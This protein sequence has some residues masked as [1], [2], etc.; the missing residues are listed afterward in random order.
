M[1]LKT[2]IA[3][4]NLSSG[5]SSDSVSS[6]E[7]SRQN[8]H[9][10]SVSGSRASSRQGS[11]EEEPSFVPNIRL[12]T[13]ITF[14]T[15]PSSMTFTDNTVTRSTM[16]KRQKPKKVDLGHRRASD[17]NFQPNIVVPN[18]RPNISVDP[19]PS[20]QGDQLASSNITS[21]QID[22][23]SVNIK[24]NTWSSPS[25]VVP[26]NLSRAASV[27]PSMPGNVVSRH[28]VKIP[29]PATPSTSWFSS[30]MVQTAPR[31]EQT[32]SSSTHSQSSRSEHTI[33]DPPAAKLSPPT[34]QRLKS[35]IQYPDTQQKSNIVTVTVPNTVGHG[36]LGQ[37][38]ASLDLPGS[39]HTEAGAIGAS[40]I[41]EEESNIP[42][43]KMNFPVP[44]TS[45]FI[46]QQPP[47]SSISQ[48]KGLMRKPKN[49]V[50]TATLMAM[51]S[52]RGDIGMDTVIKS[53]ETVRL[54]VKDDSNI[55]QSSSIPT[56]VNSNVRV[57][58]R[59]STG[60]AYLPQPTGS[61]SFQAANLPTISARDFSPTPQQ[62]SSSPNSCGRRAL[63]PKKKVMK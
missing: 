49:E 56:S 5:S 63:K 41:A 20:T 62:R 40:N 57:D 4:F 45:D 10:S 43:S 1:S 52:D 48:N 16:T 19:D 9:D 13:S 26:R 17:D 44:R 30:T 8:S 33:V 6:N 23:P 24:S 25:F 42:M 15:Q 22:P 58:R 50:N 51:V 35:N 31:S 37:R 55:T 14:D 39:T 32:L 12:P 28:T 29:S 18:F 38:S 34:V 3:F 7:S 2:Y 36:I 21:L 53:M 60:N 59:F 61:K 46:P 54:G 47:P 11:R 27:P